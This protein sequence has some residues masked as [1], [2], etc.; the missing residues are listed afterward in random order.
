MDGDKRPT[1]QFHFLE[2]AEQLNADAVHGCEIRAGDPN[3][4][5]VYRFIVPNY[6]T[7]D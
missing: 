1:G 3:L 5:K 7:I 6:F 4:V 2:F